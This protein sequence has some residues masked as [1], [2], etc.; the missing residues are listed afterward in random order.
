MVQHCNEQDLVFNT[1]KIKFGSKKNEGS[2]LPDLEQATFVKH[3]GIA[4]DNN[5]IWD[6]DQLQLALTPQENV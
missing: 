1:T 2:T 4:I 5:L 6:M 3:L